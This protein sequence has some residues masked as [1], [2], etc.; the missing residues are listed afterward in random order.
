MSAEIAKSTGFTLS[1]EVVSVSIACEHQQAEKPQ[2]DNIVRQLS[3]LGGTPYEASR[4]E[5]P[6][7]FD[8]FIPGS[9]LSDLR[10]QLVAA[11][12]ANSQ[13]QQKTG[14][15]S[16]IEG[17]SP[18]H[19][20]YTYLN[21]VSNRLAQQVYG[22]MEPTAFELK[23]GDGPLMQC[24]HCLRFS[25]GFCTRRSGSRM[26]F[27]EPLFLRLADGRRF[28]LEFDCKQCQMN[29]YASKCYREKA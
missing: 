24:R 27:R 6:S 14:I 20:A 16:H 23:G 28:R 22:I 15:L 21:N 8:Y 26:P 9:L 4:V 2:H 29:V 5:I 11:L 17:L 25:L 13:P 12:T 3:K 10:R 18:E 1:A 19:Y 7:D